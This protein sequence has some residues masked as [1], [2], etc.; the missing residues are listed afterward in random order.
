MPVPAST[1]K[2]LLLPREELQEFLLQVQSEVA[3]AVKNLD[4]DLVQSAQSLAGKNLNEDFARDV[5]KKLY[6]GKPKLVALGGKIASTPEGEGVYSFYL[7]DGKIPVKKT[8]FWRTV[9]LHGTAWRL[10]IACAQDHM[11]NP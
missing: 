1:D 4:G 11:E 6:A 5:L 7:K 8:V 3:G 2:R 9:D 10:A